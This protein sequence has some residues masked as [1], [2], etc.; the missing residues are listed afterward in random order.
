VVLCQCWACKIADDIA[1]C[2]IGDGKFRNNI[3]NY[4]KLNELHS[5]VHL[6]GNIE[7]S[8]L[9]TWTCSADIGMAFD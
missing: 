2:L 1:I 9:H 6:T 8:Q 3:D 5:K 4:I 7:Y